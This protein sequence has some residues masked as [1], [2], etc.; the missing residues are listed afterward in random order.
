MRALDTLF[1]TLMFCPGRGHNATMLGLLFAKTDL[2]ATVSH[3][4]PVPLGLVTGRVAGIV[5]P[6]SE[7]RLVQPELTEN[8]RARVDT[9]APRKK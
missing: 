1:V 9:N 2:V 5:W 3:A 4:G 6:P 8:A 7:A